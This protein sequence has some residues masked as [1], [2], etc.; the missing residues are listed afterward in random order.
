MGCSLPRSAAAESCRSSD[1]SVSVRI[2]VSVSFPSVKVPV[3]SRTI[4]VRSPAR[5]SA[6]PFRKRMPRCAPIPVPIITAV[7][8]A[9]P[10]AHGQ[11]VTRIAT[12]RSIAGVNPAPMRN[13]HTRNVTTA[14]PVTIGTNT[15][16]TAS[17][18]RWMGGLLC[19]VVWTNWTRR[20]RGG[21]CLRCVWLP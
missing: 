17:A 5:S 18:A 2:S 12:K 3:L 4:V 14:I 11:A 6:S 7:G 15:F 1:S 21:F 16:V 8:V 9:S 20:A 10:K 13:H 19:C